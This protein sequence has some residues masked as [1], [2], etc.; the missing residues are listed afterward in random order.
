MND[1][2]CFSYSVDQLETKKATCYDV[3]VEIDDPV[4]QQM[5][6]FLL[7]QQNQAEVTALD[8]KIYDTVEQINQLKTQREFYLAFSQDPQQFIGKWI[9]SQSNDLKVFHIDRIIKSL[10]LKWS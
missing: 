5:H 6:E 2:F 8:Q 4:K 3:E 10:S 9:A 7:A 1:L